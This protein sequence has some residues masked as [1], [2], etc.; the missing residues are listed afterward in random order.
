MASLPP[1]DEHRALVKRI[2]S[3]NYFLNKQLQH[4]CNLNGMRVNGVKAELQKRI[5]DGMLGDWCAFILR[6]CWA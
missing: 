1:A 4:I 5:I 6:T 2:N 3:S